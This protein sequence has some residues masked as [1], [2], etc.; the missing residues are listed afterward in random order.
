MDFI[1]KNYNI[2]ESY[3]LEDDCA[4]IMFFIISDITEHVL[5]R[6]VQNI[7]SLKTN[8]EKK[9][10]IRTYRKGLVDKIKNNIKNKEKNRDEDDEIINDEYHAIEC[11]FSEI[12]SFFDYDYVPEKFSNK[13]FEMYKE[14][15]F[16]DRFRQYLQRKS[17]FEY[18]DEILR[19]EGMIEAFYNS[20]NVLNSI[21]E[22]D[23]ETEDDSI[24]KLFTDNRERVYDF[25][26]SDLL[27]LITE[28]EYEDYYAYYDDEEYD[29]EEDGEDYDEEED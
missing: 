17:L 22:I 9:N 24:I 2:L 11:F 3:E 21:D 7:W 25:G 19:G 10:R 29:D 13:D 18:E 5:A 26:F 15:L 12:K 27:Y 8:N 6:I 4:D 1:L 28:Q 23:D 16:N 20:I 14:I